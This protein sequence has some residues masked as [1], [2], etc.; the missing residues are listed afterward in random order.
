VKNKEILRYLA[1]LL[2]LR[3]V[4]RQ[5]VQFVH[6]RGHFGI[7]GN[8]GADYQANLGATMEER[9]ERDWDEER[10][11]VKREIDAERDRGAIA[12]P[13]QVEVKVVEEDDKLWKGME[14]LDDVD[15]L[16]SP[17]TVQHPSPAPSARPKINSTTEKATQTLAKSRSIV[18]TVAKAPSLQP[19]ANTKPKMTSIGNEDDEDAF[20]E[21]ENF[22]LDALD[23]ELRA[24]GL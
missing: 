7:E 13:A 11:N 3:H 10:E 5:K 17:D 16:D 2:E 24:Q 8:E 23:A 19:T 20:W 18:S 9:I 15:D 22:D 6:V 12:G 14:E 4:K 1:T 21:V